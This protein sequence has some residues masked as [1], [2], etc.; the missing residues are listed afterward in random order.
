[1]TTTKR[2]RADDW[3]PTLRSAVLRLAMFFAKMGMTRLRRVEAWSRLRVEL[4][5]TLVNLARKPT[6]ANDY[7]YAMAA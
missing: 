3:N 1:M 7:A 4:P 5:G 2:I 6:N